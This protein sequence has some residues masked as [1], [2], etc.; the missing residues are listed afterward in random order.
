MRSATAVVVAVLLCAPASARAD[1]GDW[2]GWQTLLTDAAATGLLYSATQFPNEDGALPGVLAVAG[3]ATY[4]LG[5]PIVHA[6]HGGHVG[7]SLA[8]RALLPV[9]GVPIGFAIYALV[10]TRSS[11]QCGCGLASLGAG[12]IG[13]GVGMIAASA[14][15]AAVFAFEPPVERPTLGLAPLLGRDRTRGVALSLRF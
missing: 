13:L 15:D 2:Y 9:A 12:V 14:V 1:E 7:R 6:I 8:A 4:L 3:L 11:D 10:H 5:G